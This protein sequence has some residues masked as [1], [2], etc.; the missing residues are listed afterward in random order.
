LG[1]RWKNWKAF[2][3]NCWRESMYKLKQMKGQKALVTGGLG[4]IGSNVAHR[5][6]GLGAKVTVYDA[7]L[8]PY[9]WNYANVREIREHVRVVKADTRD[10][11]KL[12]AHVKGQDYVFNCAGQ[13]SHLDSMK[14]PWLD[15]DINCKGNLNLLE[16]ARRFNDQ[17]RIVYCGTRAQIGRAMYSPIDEA[18]PTNPVDIYGINKL[19]GEK[20]HL[21]YADVYGMP[22]TSLRL[23]NVFG[24]RHQM[25]H[26][27]Y[28]ILN[29]FIRLALEGRDITIYGSGKQL[30]EYNYVQ[31]VVDALVLAGQ[32]R[33]AKGRFY[34]ISTR[35]AMPFLEMARQV[36]KEVGRGR[37]VKAP[38]PRERKQIEVGNVVSSY[39]KAKRELG[40]EPR[41]SF[42]AGLEKTVAFYRERLPEYV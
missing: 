2:T 14:D 7:C 12:C 41:T 33:K 36:V 31:D 13:V 11:D 16:A 1:K 17:A 24:E 32:S 6:V 42:E 29:W 40:W 30:R 9:G 39:R 21:L 23:N 38:W 18:H 20:Y 10:F 28:G 19:A 4:F 25:K 27:L 34:S 26:C 8:D 35:K 5:L 15:L 37:V 22:V 3:G